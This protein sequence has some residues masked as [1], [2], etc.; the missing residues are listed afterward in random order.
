MI[1][2]T[3]TDLER[4]EVEAILQN[5]QRAVLLQAEDETKVGDMMRFVSNETD[6]NKR[7]DVFR[8]VTHRNPQFG[9]SV[10]VSIRP[11]TNAEKLALKP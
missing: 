10:V 5:E 7:R 1:I 6:V 11:L 4:Q 3:C 2:R 8:M 9:G